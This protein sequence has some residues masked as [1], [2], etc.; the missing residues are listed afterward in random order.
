MLYHIANPQERIDYPGKSLAQ[1]F[2]KPSS[3]QY[4]QPALKS[5]QEILKELPPVPVKRQ[6]GN[7][8]S[9]DSIEIP[10]VC[11][12]YPLSQGT[13]GLI[14][15]VMDK[16][17]TMYQIKL[18]IAKEFQLHPSMVRLFSKGFELP[19]DLVINLGY[20][21]GEILYF[22]IYMTQEQLMDNKTNIAYEKY[23]LMKIIGPFY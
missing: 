14:Y 20:S 5:S 12:N 6:I 21:R 7:V 18:N 22:T 3:P 11:L 13:Y 4:D 2:P 9:P 10:L 1:R 8:G 17:D 23:E 15:S 16:G 19:N